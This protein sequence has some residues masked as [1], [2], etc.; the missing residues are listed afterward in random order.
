MTQ[1]FLDTLDAALEAVKDEPVTAVLN[2]YPNQAETLAPL[3]M[4]AEKVMD[5]QT[6]VPPTPNPS[7]QTADRAA[8]L[9]QVEQLP[10][11]AVS[12]SP[13]LR[14]KGWLTQTRAALRNR[15][16][17]KEHKPM[18]AIFAR[19]AA[20]VAVI[21]SLGSGTVALANDS[22]PETP[23][24]PVKLILEDT[25]MAMANNPVEQASLQMS[26]AQVRLQE[27]TQLTQAGD[28]IDEPLV[29]RLET[30]LQQAL[31]LAAQ[32]DETDLVG[33]LTQMQTML[34]NEQQTMT[35]QGDPAQAM[36]GSV[37]QILN[38]YQ[39]RV[40]A[41][42]DDPPMFRWRHSQNPD[43]DPTCPQGD[44]EP[45]GSGHQNGQD[46]NDNGQHGPGDGTCDGDCGPIGDENQ[47]GQD[48]NN[49]Q[50]GPGDGT[51]VSDCNPVGDEN[52]YG[53][54]DANSGQNGPG[55]GTGVCVNDCAPIGDGPQPEQNHDNGH[56]NTNDDEHGNNHGNGG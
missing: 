35:Q 44:C 10:E 31:Q 25:R 12:T 9:A 24:Y 54:D 1:L 50:N 13:F 56:G 5:W 51:C 38:Q 18:N 14:L 42:L 32:T 23:L 30:H 27:M 55:D 45:H 4:A 28:E 39:E 49:G 6:A 15:Q 34:Q 11:T 37:T 53:Q 21:I 2:R 16:V 43:R 22:L 33:L 47:Y 17:Q 3:L 19:V 26:L 36:F 8:F 41:G 52:Q 48:Q 29:S 40:Q 7:W 46:A 20:T